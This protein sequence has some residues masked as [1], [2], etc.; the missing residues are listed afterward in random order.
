VEGNLKRITAHV[1]WFGTEAIW[2]VWACLSTI[3][4][5]YYVPDFRSFPL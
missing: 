5:G 4:I 2:R 3:F 1:C